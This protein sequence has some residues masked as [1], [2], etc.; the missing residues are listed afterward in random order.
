MKYL[1]MKP[2]FTARRGH[3]YNLKS[4][5]A[6][7]LYHLPYTCGLYDEMDL[8]VLTL[9]LNIAGRDLKLPAAISNPEVMS[10]HRHLISSDGFTIERCCAN[11]GGIM[12]N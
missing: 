5:M 7:I 4:K 6:T 9:K 12:S 3:H 8:D 1:T 10:V 2:L 11:G